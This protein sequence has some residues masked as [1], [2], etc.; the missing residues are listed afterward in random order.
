[1]RLVNG[2]HSAA[3]DASDRGLHYGDGLFETMAVVDGRIPLWDR[4]LER[5]REGCRRLGF[6]CPD[7]A[8]LAAEAERL[9][10]DRPRCVLKLIVT[11]GRG[12]LYRPGC[13]ATR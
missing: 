8:V 2:R 1:M 3:L 4:H 9:T 10:A 12:G 5:L 13:T 7:E 11:R 6:D